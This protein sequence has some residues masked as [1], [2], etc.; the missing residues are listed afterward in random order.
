L[1]LAGAMLLCVLGLLLPQ[2]IHA[3]EAGA[4]DLS[5]VLEYLPDPD[6][7]LTL[8]D[9]TRPP[10]AEQFTRDHDGIFNAG[11]RLSPY[12]YRLTFALPG[13]ADAATRQLRY[14]EI[15]FPM[16]DYLDAYLPGRDGGWERIETGDQR[17][18]GSRPV[19]GRN[20]IFPVE[21][22]SG[23]PVTLYFRVQSADPQVMPVRL[24]TYPEYYEHA[25]VVLMLLG[26]F[27]GVSLVMLLYNAFVF[28]LLRER[29]YLDYVILGIFM[30]LLWPL[31]LDGLG[32]QYLWGESPRWINLSSAF[33]ACLSGALGARFGQ[34]F[35]QIRTRL[36]LMHQWLNGYQLACLAWAGLMFFVSY[37]LANLV[38]LALAVVGVAG[39]AMTIVRAQRQGVESVRYMTQ[40]GV[41]VLANV[42]VK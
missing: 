35:L 11:Y 27:Y 37:R 12:W 9:V 7:Q 14:L 33:N 26:A 16:L 36:P 29:S 41:A 20:F 22:P 5:P 24:W 13:G 40:A 21:L 28:T 19:P 10:L 39:I 34:S 17:P 25:Q 30:S 1:A 2:A 23:R 32:A 6:G 4:M 3:A 18:R 31:S 15:A 42:S 38:T 8:D